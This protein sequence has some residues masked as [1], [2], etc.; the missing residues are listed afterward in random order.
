M[1][2]RLAAQPHVEFND[3]VRLHER[4]LFANLNR[5][6]AVEMP[7]LRKATKRVAFLSGLEK[8]R[9]KTA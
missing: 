2:E 8:S 5:E 6:S 7:P 1:V 4:G 3:F 9:S